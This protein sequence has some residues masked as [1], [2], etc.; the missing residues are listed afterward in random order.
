MAGTIDRDEIV[1]RLLE[2]GVEPPTWLDEWLAGNET[3]LAD[4]C[5]FLPSPQGLVPV[6]FWTDG[7]NRAVNRIVKGFESYGGDD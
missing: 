4:Q 6:I 7:L 1:R 5:V 2:L 3:S